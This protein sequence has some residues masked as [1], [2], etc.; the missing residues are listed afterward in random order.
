[1]SI[2]AQVKCVPT[3]INATKEKT[4]NNLKL[5][6]KAIVKIKKKHKFL[7]NIIKHKDKDTYINHCR[8][9]N[10]VRLETRHSQKEFEK[11]ISA[12]VKQQ[13]MLFWSYLLS[14]TRTKS[15][16]CGQTYS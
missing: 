3:K 10:Q 11:K 1:M 9:R 7:K 5:N 16:K 15:G 13:P 2:S 12:S 4:W 8:L 6:H 14:I